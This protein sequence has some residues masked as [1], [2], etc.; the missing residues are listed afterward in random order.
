[1]FCNIY[2]KRI[3]AALRDPTT[4]VWTWVFPLMM[5]TLFYFAFGSL[6][7]TAQ[8]QT[9]PVAVVRDSAYQQDQTLQTALQQ[10]SQGDS[11]LLS[12]TYVDSTQQADTLLRLY[13]GR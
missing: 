2:L 13:P 11:A 1:M 9:V 12:I 3:R 7:E 8:L 10:V 6:D 4:L 5:A